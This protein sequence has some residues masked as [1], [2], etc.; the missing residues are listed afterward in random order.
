[1]VLETLGKLL[2]FLDG[3]KESEEDEA[4]RDFKVASEVVER[5]WSESMLFVF[6]SS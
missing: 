3:K 5:E 4:R 2:G 1:M 6:E